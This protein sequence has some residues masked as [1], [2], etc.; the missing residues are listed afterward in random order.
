MLNFQGGNPVR[1]QQH[2]LMELHECVHPFVIDSGFY[3][4]SLHGKYLDQALITS[5]V[6][7]RRHETYTFC[8]YVGKMTPTF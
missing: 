1:P 3:E 8:L 6:E 4:I 5:L 7:R 2:T